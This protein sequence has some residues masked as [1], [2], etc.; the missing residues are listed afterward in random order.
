MKHTFQC[1]KCESTDVIKIEGQRYNQNHI[2]SLTNWGTN[3]AVI[4]RFL[5]THCGYTEE[6]LQLTSK[7]KKWV[8][9]NKDKGNLAS[10]FV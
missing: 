8:A 3:H 1:P 5:C 7:F 2:V 10:D 9:K 4:D 6:W